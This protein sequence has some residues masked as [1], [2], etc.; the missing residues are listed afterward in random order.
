MA[1]SVPADEVQTHL[2]DLLEEHT[3]FVITKDGEPVARVVPIA[4]RQ[5]RRLTLEELRRSGRI[6]GD[7]LEPID[8]WDVEK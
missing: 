5:R 4:E 6:V 2:L 7:I 1:K 8:E 3:E